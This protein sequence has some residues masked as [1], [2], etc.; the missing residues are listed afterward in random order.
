[1]DELWPE[2]GYAVIV[3]D[4]MKPP[5]SDDF[6]NVLDQFSEPDFELPASSNS[7]SY[8]VHDAHGNRYYREEWEQFK[9]MQALVTAV[10]TV[11]DEQPVD[12]KLTEL[13]ERG[14][15]RWERDDVLWFEIVLSL[16]TQG[17]SRGAQLVVDEEGA[18]NEERYQRVSFETLKQ[19]DPEER[20]NTVEE[21]VRAAKVSRPNQTTDAIIRN[22]ETVDAEYG[23]PG[24]LKSAFQ[25]TPTAEGKL[26]F[27]K[28]F[29]RIGKK[30]SRNICMDL[31]LEEFRDRIAIDRRIEGILDTAEIPTDRTYEEQEEFLRSVAD[32]LDMKPWAL[33]RTLYNFNEEI[34][35]RLQAQ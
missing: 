23:S 28:S 34:Q 12:E 8:W 31:Y 13:R 35:S 30:Y 32:E 18:I 29:H 25:D 11:R 27:L 9:P 10:E 14:Q 7:Y 2:D 3:E 1:M 15:Q 20:P 26:D 5:D 22:F 21:A 33:D 24:A 17:N 19:L 4:E 6:V 16:A